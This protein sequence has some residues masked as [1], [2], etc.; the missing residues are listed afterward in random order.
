MTLMVKG[1]PELEEKNLPKRKTKNKTK[2]ILYKLNDDIRISTQILTI[3][4]KDL[5]H[6]HCNEYI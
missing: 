6:N 4:Q 5:S 1:V 2:H 3:F